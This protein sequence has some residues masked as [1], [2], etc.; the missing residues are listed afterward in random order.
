MLAGAISQVSS[1]TLGLQNQ[2][3]FSRCLYPFYSPSTHEVSYLHPHQPQPALA[4]GFFQIWDLAISLL[5]FHHQILTRLSGPRP[6]PTW[7]TLLRPVH[8]CVISALVPGPGVNIPGQCV[9][10]R[11]TLS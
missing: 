6:F 2:H 4:L 9:D 11:P 3:N 8:P 1:T 5:R 10:S 7:F